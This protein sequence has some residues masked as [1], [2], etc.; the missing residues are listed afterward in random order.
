MF[1]YS[2]QYLQFY[3]NEV[4]HCSVDNAATV[5]KLYHPIYVGTDATHI[6][7]G[8]NRIHDNKADGAILFHST[9]GSDLFD[10]AVHDNEIHDNPGYGIAFAQIDPSK[11]P[12]RVYNNLIYRVGQGP[13]PG[14][15]TNYAA[16]DVTGHAMGRGDVVVFNNTFYDCGAE[17]GGNAGTFL[18]GGHN[19]NIRLVLRNNIV[20]SVR[21]ERYFA[22]TC[23]TGLV[24]GTN[25]LF[26]G[27]GP[28]PEFLTKNLNADP[29][30]VDPERMNFRLR[31]GSPAI[32]AGRD[33]PDILDDI[34]GVPRPKGSNPSLGAHEVF[35]R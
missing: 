25:N 12:V 18:N 19:P 4:H 10:L 13:F 21:G 20:F 27:C 8:W 3:G 16:I 24:I 11:G 32:G 31:P 34:E 33:G 23:K 15:A 35:G 28:G 7:I 2:P 9:G 26:F 29:L 22:P 6:D 30:L 17:G 14:G 5:G 1:V